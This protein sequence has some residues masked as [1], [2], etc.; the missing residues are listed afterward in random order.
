MSTLRIT[1]DGRAPAKVVDWR[2]VWKTLLVEAAG[3]TIHHLEFE[4]DEDGRAR[5]RLRLDAQVLVF[6]GGDRLA[7]NSQLL[8]SDE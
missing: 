7:I 6:E 8:P 3:Q 2:D 1:S 5:V 4:R